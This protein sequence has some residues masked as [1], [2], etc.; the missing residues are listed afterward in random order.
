LLLDPENRE[1]TR[2]DTV[3]LTSKVAGYYNDKEEL[4]LGLID[5]LIQCSTTHYE[6]SSRYDDDLNSDLV[7][8]YWVDEAMREAFKFHFGASEGGSEEESKA[9]SALNLFQSL[10]TLLTLNY[11][12]VDEPSPRLSLLQK[13]LH[14]Y[15]APPWNSQAVRSGNDSTFAPRWVCSRKSA[16]SCIIFARPLRCWAWL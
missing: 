11:F 1:D 16:Q 8:D 10:Q 4:Q 15:A 3:E 6:D 2:V 9:K 13:V 12:Q 14:R 7:L 5:K